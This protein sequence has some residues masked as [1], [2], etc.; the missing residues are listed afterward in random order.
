[1]DYPWVFGGDS[2]EDF[3]SAV[4][5]MI[6]NDNH[7]EG[8]SGFLRQGGGHR[9]GDGAGAVADGDDYRGLNGKVPLREVN[10]PCYRRKLCH[11]SCEV[12]GENLFTLLLHRGIARINIVKLFLPR[13]P[14][15]IFRTD[16]KVFRNVTDMG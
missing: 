4:G 6:V 5:R 9:V 12:S 11:D 14:A 13:S 15:V 8:E 1:M 7:I 3:G 10:L 2:G 16:V